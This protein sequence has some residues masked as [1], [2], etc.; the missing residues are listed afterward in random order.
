MLLHKGPVSCVRG[1]KNFVGG[2]EQLI[3]AVRFT[4]LTPAIVVEFS[5]MLNR[6]NF[7]ALF[8][9]PFLFF[10]F[11]LITVDVMRKKFESLDAVG[12]S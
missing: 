4:L 5:T 6:G 11:I 1:Q 10:D 9:F 7:G 3:H 12:S 2:E 8:P